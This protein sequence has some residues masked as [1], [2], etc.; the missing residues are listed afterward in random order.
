MV[1]INPFVIPITR[2][3]IN[4][5]VII[6]VRLE[7]NAETSC[8]NTLRKNGQIRTPKTRSHQKIVDRVISKLNRPHALRKA[9][10]R[11]IPNSSLA[12]RH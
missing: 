1:K 11:I 2:L 5:T 3:A 7:E 4:P 10:K 6:L 12:Y 9:V 8:R